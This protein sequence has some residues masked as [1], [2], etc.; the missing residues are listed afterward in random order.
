[1]LSYNDTTEKPSPVS[2]MF[3]NLFLHGVDGK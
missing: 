3:N 1:M 2:P